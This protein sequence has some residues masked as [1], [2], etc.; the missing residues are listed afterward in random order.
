M[1]AIDV[2]TI[3]LKINT[4]ILIYCVLRGW[5]CLALIRALALHVP[6]TEP[7]PNLIVGMSI[8]LLDNITSCC[9]AVGCSPW[10]WRVIFPPL[11]DS[12]EYH[13]VEKVVLDISSTF[14]TSRIMMAVPFRI[15]SPYV[16]KIVKLLYE[17]EDVYSSVSCSDELCTQRIINA[18]YSRFRD[19]DVDVYTRFAV[20]FGSWIE[21]PYFPATAN[22]SNIVGFSCSLRYTD[23][24]KKSFMEKREDII[25]R[26]I[27]DVDDMLKSLS[28]YSAIPYLGIDASL[29]PWFTESVAE[30]IELIAGDKLGCVGSFYTIHS[31]NK[32]IEKL[33]NRL[34]MKSIG[35]N[36]VMLSVAEDTLLNE[37]VKDGLVKLK[38]LLSFSLFCVPGID[39]IAI[40]QSIDY[41]RL[42]LDMLTIYRVKKVS[43]ALRV[44]PT[45]LESGTRI[46][47]K[48]FGETYV[49]QI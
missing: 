7:K 20:V 48:R 5:V 1:Q 31:L 29:S 28:N 22:I 9:K 18:I 10:T 47:L 12:I 11:P 44:I 32:Y 36:E 27:L 42:L 16:D 40:P 6:I 37:R 19:V 35:Y 23:L 43:T 41:R 24:A 39:M 49:I 8:K 45:D 34:K 33:I 4:V 17:N 13:D 2:G 21:S 3:S 26:F 14:N 30:V 25:L 15:D 38:D 46:V